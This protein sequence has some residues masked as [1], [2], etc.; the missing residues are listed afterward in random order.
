[1]PERKLAD[2]LYQNADERFSRRIARKIV[3]ERAIS[4]I[5]TTRRL[6]EI[7][8]SCVPPVRS[9]SAVRE[10]IDPATRTFLALR[11]Q[12]NAEAENLK[13]LIDQASARLASEGRL[14]II[15]FQSAEDRIVK[16][17]FKA[18]EETNRFEVLT[19]KPIVPTD[20]E[21]ESNP[22]SRSSKMRVLKRVT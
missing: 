2:M 21:I 16:H 17:A 11:M 20:E 13:A 1:W 18:L 22:R 8:R 4:P 19:K 10:P 3:E 7:V 15:S 14:A 6:A 9:K 12:V 5:K